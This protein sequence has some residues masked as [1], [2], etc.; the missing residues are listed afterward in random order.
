MDAGKEN[1]LVLEIEQADEGL[2]LHHI[3]EEELG[4]V[5]SGDAGGQYTADTTSRT[6]QIAHRLGKD[7]VLDLVPEAGAFVPAVP[8]RLLVL[9]AR[10]DGAPIAGVKVSVS[11]AEEQALSARTDAIGVATVD[12]PP[13][14]LRAVTG[15]KNAGCGANKLSV[16]ATVETAGRES[17][18]HAKELGPRD[19]VS[20]LGE[21]LVDAVPEAA[22][23]CR[24][25][26]L[27]CIPFW[28]SVLRH[29][30]TRSRQASDLAP[31]STS[32]IPCMPRDIAH[33]P[34]R[35]QARAHE[36]W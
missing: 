31:A 9:A 7:S 5:V 13:S 2:F 32:P 35:A 17:D 11:I 16:Q 10:P 21:A 29:S 3:L 33:S 6:K 18:R 30:P 23:G 26:T 24:C 4:G 8:N 36:N 28:L 14:L 27:R 12:V 15:A 34:V 22:S 19:D 1:S 20:D 25:R